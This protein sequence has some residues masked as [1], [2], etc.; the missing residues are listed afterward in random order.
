[1]R[2]QQRVPNL[3]YVIRGVKRARRK[4][5]PVTRGNVNN[6][7]LSLITGFGVLREVTIREKEKYEW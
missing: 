2:L 3:Q 7:L 5:S 4:K 6:I 1:M